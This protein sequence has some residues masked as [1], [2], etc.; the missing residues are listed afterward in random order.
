MEEEP[1]LSDGTCCAAAILAKTPCLAS[2]ITFGGFPMARPWLMG[3]GRGV[4]ARCV[5][6][7]GISSARRRDN[8]RR[9]AD[10]LR[11]QLA[12]DEK[13]LLELDEIT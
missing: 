2:A 11:A 6:A 13:A 12:K 7:A 10:E 8:L 1:L 4:G 3:H 9:S 5:H